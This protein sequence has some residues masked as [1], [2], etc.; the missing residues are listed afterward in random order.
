M[1][2][3]LEITVFLESTEKEKKR[4]RTQIRPTSPHSSS[5][6]CQRRPAQIIDCFASF[7]EA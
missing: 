7:C 2:I 1:T 4:R 3:K 5:K 6:P